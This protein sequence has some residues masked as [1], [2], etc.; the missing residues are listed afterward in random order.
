MDFLD[1][2]LIFLRIR[3]IGNVSLVNCSNEKNSQ[4]FFDDQHYVLKGAS[5]ATATQLLR[6]SFRNWY[7]DVYPYMFAKFRCCQ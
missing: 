7:Q 6:K 5:F 4:D 3:V 1:F 2:Q